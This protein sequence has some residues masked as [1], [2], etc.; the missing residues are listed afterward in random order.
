[1]GGTDSFLQLHPLSHS[2]TPSHTAL[3]GTL[4]HSQPGLGFTQTLPRFTHA[5]SLLAVSL[6]SSS[7]AS[8]AAALLALSLLILWTSPGKAEGRLRVGGK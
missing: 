8:H 2:Q 4:T 1:M 3:L 7:M 5:H 6:R